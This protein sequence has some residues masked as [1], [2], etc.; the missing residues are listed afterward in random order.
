MLHE[1]LKSIVII[2]ILLLLLH[3]RYCTYTYNHIFIHYLL[4]I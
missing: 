2:A 1:I 3:V 4:Y